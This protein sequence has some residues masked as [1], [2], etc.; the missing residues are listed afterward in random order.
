MARGDMRRVALAVVVACLVAA[1][2][3]QSVENNGPV[4]DDAKKAYE[5]GLQYLNHRA[6]S[7]ALDEFKKADKK[8]GGHC[9]ACEMQIVKCA[10][11]EHDWK[12]AETAAREIEAAAQKPQEIALA[13]YQLGSVFLNEGLDKRK[14]EFFTR[15]HD[16]MTQALTA[17]ANF[18][19]AIFGDA[20]ALARLKQDDAAKAQF[21]QFLSVVSSDNPLRERAARYASQ[22]ELVRARMAPPFR[23]TTLDGQDISLDGLQGKV[24]LI[25]F[26]ATWCAACV[27][28]MPHLRD[29]AKKFKDEPLVILSISLDKDPALWKT[30]VTK[31]EMVW[32]QYCDGGWTGPITKLFDVHAIPQTF[33]IDAEGVLQDQHIGDASIEKKLKKLVE[34]ARN[35]HPESDSSLP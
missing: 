27:S 24:V 32:P 19:A 26:W 35:A 30:Y 18:P 31:N 13:H 25:D 20:Q 16:E 23:V 1:C 34:Q 4:S 2:L 33:T 3:A 5:K 8:D 11:Q 14:D 17:V 6:A 10:I 21:Q 9:R 7:S 15:A 29:I 12:A 22:P 28:A